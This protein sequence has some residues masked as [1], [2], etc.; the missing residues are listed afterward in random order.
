MQGKLQK[1]TKGHFGT[2][3]LSTQCSFQLMTNQQIDSLIDL[4]RPVQGTAFQFSPSV[5]VSF[6]V[7]QYPT[8]K[9]LFYA[10][11]IMQIELSYLHKTPLGLMVFVT[12][13]YLP[14]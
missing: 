14:Q 12:V 10:G 5:F 8:H 9:D 3:F 13:C 1:L 6:F 2:F 11:R 7:F 4:I